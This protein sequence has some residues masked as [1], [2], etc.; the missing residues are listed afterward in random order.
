MSDGQI[1]AR[2]G[3]LATRDVGLSSRIVYSAALRTLVPWISAFVLLALAIA[4][5]PLGTAFTFPCVTGMLSQVIPN[6]ERGLYMGVQQTFGGAARIIGPIWAG[7]AFD[8]LGTGV[9]FFTGAAL[10]LVTIAIG[11]GM[12]KHLPERVPKPVA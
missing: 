11:A 1:L 2:V 6:H 4:L 5:V 9:P 7:F 12:E 8:Y 10:A 3:D